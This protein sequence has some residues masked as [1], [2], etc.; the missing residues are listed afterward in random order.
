LIRLDDAITDGLFRFSHPVT[1]AY[2][3]CGR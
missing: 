3:W 2:Y 1:C